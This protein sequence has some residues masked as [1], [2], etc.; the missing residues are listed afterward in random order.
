MNVKTNATRTAV[1]T[2]LRDAIDEEV[3]RLRSDTL[4][5]LLDAREALGVKSLD[6]TL[7]DG[8][9][10]AAVTLTE[11]S[12]RM[13]VESEAAFTAF[14]TQHYPDEIQT[15]TRVRDGFRKAFLDRLV[16]AGDNDAAD[17]DT[18][19]VVPGITCYPPGKPRQFSMRFAKTGRQD[20]IDAWQAGALAELDTPAPHALT[21]KGA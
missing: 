1:L 16:D 12:T 13:A 11:P 10:V 20:V 17:P 8:T 3:R 21:E 9:K 5:G 15:V 2:A 4:T 19:Q 18:G 7:P 14:V 6:V